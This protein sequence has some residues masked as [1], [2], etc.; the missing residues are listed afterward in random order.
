[1]EKN[2]LEE[3]V[4]DK[5]FSREHYI[6]GGWNTEIDGSGIAYMPGSQIRPTSNLILYAQWIPWTHTICYNANG[7]TGA[8]SNQI[9]KAGEVLN[10]SN[11]I[12]QRVGY[13]FV[14]WN[15]SS[16]GSGTTYRQGEIYNVDQNGGI[17]TLYAQWESTVNLM[18]E[19][20]YAY[21]SNIEIYNVEYGKDYI[22]FNIITKS[23]YD[24]LNIPIC[25]LVEG[26]S[27]NISF[28]RDYTGGFN[29]QSNFGCKMNESIV[30]NTGSA[31]KNLSFNSKS[32]GTVNGSFNFTASSSTMYW[33]WDLSAL[34]DNNVKKYMKLYNIKVVMQ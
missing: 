15:T 29:G 20:R 34:R 24:K 9:K 2:E 19:I 6:F 21:P 31:T 7:G 11:I 28:T 10:I 33:V 5:I 13:K 4:S 23:G 25:G 16:N 22:S 14:N 3:N 18:T 8:P 17:I 32:T 1:M 12:P 27:Y 30:S 26:Y